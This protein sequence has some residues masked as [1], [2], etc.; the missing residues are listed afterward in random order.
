[1]HSLQPSPVPQHEILPLSLPSLAI[2]LAVW[3]VVHV[4]FELGVGKNFMNHCAGIVVAYL[5]GGV[6][7]QR[8]IVWWLLAIVLEGKATPWYVSLQC[9]VNSLV[10]LLVVLKWWE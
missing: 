8:D 4:V 6:H 3:F 1:M 2:V 7:P 10:H 5:I 9:V